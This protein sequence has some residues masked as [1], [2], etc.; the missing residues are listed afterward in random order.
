[1]AVRQVAPAC[2][3]DTLECKLNAV[4]AGAAAP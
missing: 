4:A 1:V 3:D 2:N